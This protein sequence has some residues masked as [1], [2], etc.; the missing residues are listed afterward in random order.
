MY[1]VYLNGSLLGQE[2]D[3]KEAKV[4]AV[5]QFDYDERY[6]EGYMESGVYTLTSINQ[7][8]VVEII[9]EEEEPDNTEHF[10][11]RWSK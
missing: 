8:K 11:H 2:E 1:K 6:S 10:E 9:A 5:N 4:G 7:N 3:W